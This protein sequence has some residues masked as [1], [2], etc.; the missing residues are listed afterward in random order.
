MAG[1]LR[2][3]A[4]SHARRRIDVPP[5]A[6]SH[7]V[8]PTSERAREAL[9]SSLLALPE[10]PLVGGYI[11]DLFAGTGALAFEALS[12]G[13]QNAV[14]VEQNRSVAKV[15]QKN[16]QTLQFSS[17]AT[18]IQADAL[19][20]VQQNAA[21]P[22]GPV[23]AQGFSVIFADPPYAMTP[24]Q[25]WADAVARLLDVGGVFV[26]ERDAQST[27]IVPVG[28]ALVRERFYGRARLHVWQ[29]KE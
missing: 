11:L 4:G 6:D 28:L 17:S 13:A 18:L 25:A 26:F 29:R 23:P 15:I 10:S 3:I 21:N 27:P 1:Q 20:W 9:F 22:S 16:I 7:D 5:E 24:T 8:R 2:I 19:L 12:R 14:L